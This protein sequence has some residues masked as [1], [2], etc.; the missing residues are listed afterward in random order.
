M[1]EKLTEKYNYAKT[2][3]S[4]VRGKDD[5]KRYYY[6]K[7]DGLQNQY[8]IYNSK[9]LDGEAELFFD[10]N[11]MASDGTKALGVTA[12]AKSGK[13]WAYGVSASGSDWQ[14]IYIKDIASKEDLKDSA[15]NIEKCEWVKFSGISWLHDDSGFF[16]SRYPAPVAL[17]DDNFESDDVKRGSETDSNKNM[18]VYFHKIG[19]PQGEDTKIFEIPEEP[20]HMSRCFISFVRGLWPLAKTCAPVYLCTACLSAYLWIVLTLPDHPKN[21]RAD[22]CAKIQQVIPFVADICWC[23][24]YD[25]RLT[26][27]CVQC[28]GFRLWRIPP[29]NGIRV[30]RAHEQTILDQSQRRHGCRGQGGHSASHQ[31][32]RHF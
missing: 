22:L 19:T 10:P 2:G 27:F 6:Y 21:D 7:N 5:S 23:N 16:Y 24:F 12:F 8:A 17:A 32:Y 11:T 14:T 13:S 18:M 15:G 30:D 29:H 20:K 31:N 25:T 26:F 9:T 3:S 4:F 28:R 1:Q